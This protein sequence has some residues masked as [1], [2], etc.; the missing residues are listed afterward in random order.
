MKQEFLKIKTADNIELAGILYEPI[1]KTNRIVLHVHGLAGNFYENSFVDCQAKTYIQNG[2]SYFT[3]NNRGNGYF[4]E[5]R[6]NDNNV[7]SYINGGAAFENFEDCYLDIKSAVD[8]VKSLGYNEIILQGHSYGCN[9]AVYYYYKSKDPSIS[10]IIL[11]A[12][13]DIIKEFQVFIGEEYSRYIDKCKKA[14]ESNNE[15]KIIDYSL[16]PPMGFTA[17]TF[18]SSFTED[19]PN[20]FYRYRTD[21]YKCSLLNGITLPVLV[22]IGEDDNSALVVD[23]NIVT[24][25]LITNIKNI[26][27]KYIENSNHGYIG[28]EQEMSDNCITWL[29]T[30]CK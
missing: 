21:N 14:I 28:K 15:N 20:D 16:F 24:N 2:Y 4:N 8:Y 11:L 23:K 10:N 26:E 6:K 3:F 13:C 18:I 27:L 29:N 30:H 9:K 19:S 7:V 12:P 22:Q 25:Y 5:L 1:D 17:K